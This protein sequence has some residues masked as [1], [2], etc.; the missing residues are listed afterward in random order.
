[1]WHSGNFFIIKNN[2]NEIILIKKSENLF[3]KIK[4]IVKNNI[5]F[6]NL[7]FKIKNNKIQK[8]KSEIKKKFRFFFGKKSFFYQK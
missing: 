8:K 3:L 1:M 7:I 4:K 6:W 2:I 5:K